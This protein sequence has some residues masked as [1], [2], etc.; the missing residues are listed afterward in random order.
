MIQLLENIRC[1][2]FW[3]ND[4]I[5]GRKYRNHYNDISTLLNSPASDDTE[6]RLQNYL[7]SLLNHAVTT[8]SFYKNLKGFASLTDFPVLNKTLIRNSISTHLSDRYKSNELIKTTTSGST[9]APF[10]VLKDS[11]KVIRHHAENIYFSEI[12]N[13]PLGSRIYYLR[14]WN[15][16]NKK[17]FLKSWLQN[18]EMVDASNLSDDFFKTLTD[19]LCVDKSTKTILAFASTLEAY[20]AYLQKN[21]IT[22]IN[23]KINSVISISETLPT[24]ARALLSRALNCPVISRYSNI[25][26]GFIGQQKFDSGDYVINQASFKVE[27]LHP[28]K[29][30]S[31]AAGAEGRIVITDLFNYAMPLIR[32]DT[33]DMAVMQ[34]DD[35]N[36]TGELVFQ[37]I[38]GRRVDY[39]FNTRGEK[40]SPH[41]ITNTMWKYAAEVSQFQFIQNDS[42]KYLLKLNCLGNTFPSKQTL[43]EELK[44]FVGN[45]AD[46]ELELVDNIP[47]LASGKRKKI[48]N[49]FRPC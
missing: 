26:N 39:I 11:N 47:V 49:N 7:N 25:E 37:S 46:I 36:G 17:G 42:N 35:K 3:L 2:A 40:L 4:F 32:Y 5:K 8:T 18:I 45:D 29:D 43:L 13:S 19:K 41:V 14:V 48:V 12:A 10:T 24:G 30:E 1:E 6:K 34:A 23:S 22:Q 28:D 21:G 20:A 15:Q 27:L 9:G 38:E 44:T 16:I 33:G 31:V